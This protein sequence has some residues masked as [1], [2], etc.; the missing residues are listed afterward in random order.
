MDNT[1]LVYFLYVGATAEPDDV[2]VHQL[3]P[4]GGVWL[5]EEA[6]HGGPG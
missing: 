4:G 3:L 2:Q 5:A 6:E 1:K